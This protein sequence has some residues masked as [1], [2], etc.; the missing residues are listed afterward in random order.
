MHKRLIEEGFNRRYVLVPMLLAI[1]LVVLGFCVG[2]VR[3]SQAAELAMELRDRQAVMRVI[4]ETMYGALEAESAQRGFLLTGEE[5]YLPPLETG[6]A[7]TENRLRDLEERLRT[8]AP[9]ELHVIQGVEDDLRVKAKEMRDSVGL[10]L[11]GRPGEARALVKQGLG[12]YQMFA[13]SQALDS[14]RSRE[15]ERFETRLAEWEE[16]TR[17]NFLINLGSMLFTVALLLVVGLLA[18]RDLRRRETF[19]TQLVAQIDERTAELQD[20]SRHMSRV[21]EAEKHAL[22]RELH[23]ELGGLLVA[24]RI[25]LAQLRKR[26]GPF[27]DPDVLTRWERVDQALSQGLELKRRVIEDL[28]PTLLDNMG[29]FTALRWLA[30]QRAEQAKLE[31]RLEGLDEDV[32]LASEVAIAV[33]RTA[34]EAIS[35][36]VNHAGASSFSV[37]ARVDGQRLTLEIIDDGKG[38]PQGAER[39]VGSHGLKQM[40]FRIEA[41]GG[42][43]AVGPHLPR[44]TVVT[45]SV[46]MGPPE[47]GTAG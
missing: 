45:L 47:A 11:E 26:I 32:E 37:R 30:Q 13:I 29:L 42:N 31:L 21:A 9:D 43:L 25:D 38:I 24:M 5:Q 16:A 46:E 28:R 23:D 15:Y 7:V 17:A 34:Q 1:V 6:L 27:T 2:E 40:R 36:I 35:N 12:L 39:R 44:G 10:H 14:L 20:L 33:F 8:L 19:A 4:A 41:V 3:R 22:A 18:T